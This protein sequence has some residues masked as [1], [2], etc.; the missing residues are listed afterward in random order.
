MVTASP[1]PQLP[2]AGLALHHAGRDVTVGTQ[3]MHGG[4]WGLAGDWLQR[5]KLRN[6]RW[7]YQHLTTSKESKIDILTF[8]S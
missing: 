4:A 6:H 5:H 1:W 7:L 3:R 8:K 2:G